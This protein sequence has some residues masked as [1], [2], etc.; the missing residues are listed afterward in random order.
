MLQQSLGSLQPSNLCS[1]WCDSLLALVAVEW[2]VRFY[3][4]TAVQLP[5]QNS[6]SAAKRRMHMCVTRRKAACNTDG[7]GAGNRSRCMVQ[8]HAPLCCPTTTPD[9]SCRRQGQARYA[10]CRSSVRNAAIRSVPMFGQCSRVIWPAL[11]HCCV[12]P[13]APP[14]HNPSRACTL[15]CTSALGSHGM[16]RAP[17]HQCIV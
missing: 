12:Q 10:R 4:R 5:V 2:P 6:A 1:W 14:H 8:P 3:Q 15:P 16:H 17:P 13:H 9:T 7:T 11:H